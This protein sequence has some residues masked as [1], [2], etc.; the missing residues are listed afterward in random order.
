MTEAEILDGIAGVARRHLGWEGSLRPEHHLVEDLGLDS[1]KLLTLAVEVENH[2]RVRL[3]DQAIVTVG[4][5]V[6][7]IH[8]QRAG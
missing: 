4:D 3:D 7:A 6:A 5:L 8:A 1:L 2:F